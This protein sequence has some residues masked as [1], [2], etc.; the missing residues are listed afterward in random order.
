M[1]IP[2]VQLPEV[3]REDLPAFNKHICPPTF[4]G[5]PSG[6]AR[7]PAMEPNPAPRAVEKKSPLLAP[8]ENEKYFPQQKKF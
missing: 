6:P 2:N 1:V 3:P 8:S 7:G 4:G 5:G